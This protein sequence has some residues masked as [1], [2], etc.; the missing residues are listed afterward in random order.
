[1]IT[2]AAGLGLCG[3]TIDDSKPKYLNSS[4]SELYHKEKILYGLHQAIKAK[5]TYI[6]VVEG[7]MDVI[8]LHQ[9]GFKGA[10]ASLGTG[11]HTRAI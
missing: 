7:Y 3:R 10:V 4:D 1:M 9:A 8:A 5:S 6:I 11:V 2:L